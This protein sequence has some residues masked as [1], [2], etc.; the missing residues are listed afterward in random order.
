MPPLLGLLRSNGIRSEARRPF[1][2][3]SLAC[4]HQMRAAIREMQRSTFIKNR[5]ESARCRVYDRI[6]C[7]IEKRC[8]VGS[9]IHCIR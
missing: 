2:C 6:S 8:R 4:L 3:P 7:A 1:A 5:L 9:V